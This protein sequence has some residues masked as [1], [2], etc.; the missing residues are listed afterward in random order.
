MKQNFISRS[1]HSLNSNGS[2]QFNPSEASPFSIQSMVMTPEVFISKS[3]GNG[4]PVIQ[5]NGCRK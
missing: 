1:M 2:T 3:S 5:S 4:Y